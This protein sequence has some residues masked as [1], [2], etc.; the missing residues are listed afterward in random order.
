MDWNIN[1]LIHKRFTAFVR[2]RS[3]NGQIR[4][5][6][7]ILYLI[8][9]PGS[10]KTY[11]ALE[12]CKRNTGSLYFPFRGMDERTA[13][14][15]FPHRYPQI[16]TEPCSAWEDFFR[17]LYDYTVKKRPVIFFDDPGERMDKNVFFD[18][19]LKLN[20]RLMENRFGMIVLTG[21]PWCLVDIPYFLKIMPSMT[22]P[23]IMRML[24][25]WSAEDVF[26]LY[27]LTE[28]ILALVRE[29][30]GCDSFDAYLKNACSPGSVFLRLAPEWTGRCFRSPESYHSLLWGLANGNDRISLL[31]RFT[32]YP[33]NKCEKYLNALQDAALVI[34]EKAEGKQPHYSLAFT[35]LNAWWKIV[36]PNRD[37]PGENIEG[38]LIEYV[39]GKLVPEMLHRKAIEWTKHNVSERSTH[40]GSRENVIRKG[41]LFDYVEKS[42]EGYI[43]VKAQH[44]MTADDWPAIEKAAASVAPFWKVRLVLCAIHPFND[45]YWNLN[46]QY[47][48]LHLVQVKSL[49]GI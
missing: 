26:R 28:G 41:V 8:G 27:S 18:E 36:F 44:H 38:Q 37:I 17:Q 15:V 21:S 23:E 20:D 48:N 40:T 12:Y 6:T 46:R 22:P 16:F 43:L 11:A 24:K 9:I 31:A 25:G 3:N 5:T 4:F 35:Y 32:G 42:A 39:D 29:A 45:F 47:T 13:L 1:S 33:N 49:G 2:E 34:K 14:A 7:G 30:I 10:G 19:L